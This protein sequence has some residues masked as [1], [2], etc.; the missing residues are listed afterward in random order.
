M[1]RRIRLTGRRQLPKSSVSARLLERDHGKWIEFKIEKQE[2]FDTFPSNAKIRLRLI[3]NKCWETVDFGTVD[4][5]KTVERLSNDEFSAPSCQLRVIA[6]EKDKKGL[7]LGSTN[8][9]T[10]RSPEPKQSHDDGILLF[11]TGDISPE[12]WKLEFC[13]DDYPIL[14]VDKSIPG[15]ASWARTD[16]VFTGCVLPDV[17]RQ[18]FR[19]IRERYPDD[20]GVGW[21][22]DW[23][24]WARE[25]TGGDDEAPPG[26]EED[27]EEVARWMDEIVESFCRKHGMIEKL[28]PHIGGRE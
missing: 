16:P 3:E 19:E 21:I 15:S 12:I 17:V 7:L 26:R 23:L 20:E 4:N 2:I 22:Q 6:S 28:R 24:A 9:W 5:L 8:T 11:Q 13:D 14:Y 18:I 1:R 10:L 27:P 25:L